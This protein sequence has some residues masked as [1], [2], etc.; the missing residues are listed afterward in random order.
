MSALGNLIIRLALNTAEFTGPLDKAE[1]QAKQ[2]M[3][4][5]A[6][7]VESVRKNFTRLAVAFAAG[8][9]IK[10]L[11]DVFDGV[12]KTAAGLDDLAESTG[13]TVESLSSMTGVAKLAG[14]SMESIGTALQKLSKGLVNADEETKGA[15]KALAALGISA[16]DSAGQL[17]SPAD[18]MKEVAASLAEYR[19]GAAKTA[20]VQDLFGK[21]G[22]Q[23]LPFLKDLADAGEL[24]A[25]ITSEQ[26]AQAEQYEKAMKRL[27]SEV[28]AWKKTV[29]LEVIPAAAA[30]V[31]V[32]ADMAAESNKANAAARK[33]AKDGYFRSWADDAALSIAYVIDMVMEFKDKLVWAVAKIKL[34]WDG[35]AVGMAAALTGP[36]SDETKR[37]IAIAMETERTIAEIEKETAGKRYDQMQRRLSLAQKVRDAE[38]GL[39]DDVRDKMARGEKQILQYHAAGE[40]GAE[41]HKEKL[42]DLDKALAEINKKMNTD[43]DEARLIGALNIAFQ[44]GKVSVGEYAEKLSFLIGSLASVKKA[45]DDQVTALNASRAAQHAAIDEIIRGADSIDKQAESLEEQN[46]T[47]GVAKSSLEAL[48]IARLQN[49]KAELD[50]VEGNDETVAALEREI[51]ARERLRAALGN[52]EA[53]QAEQEAQRQSIESFRQGWETVDRTARDVFISGKESIQNLKNFLKS[54][55]IEYLYRMTLQKW[56]FQIYANVSG[57]GAGGAA[58]SAMQLASGS[59]GGGSLLNMGSNLVGSWWN[60]EGIMGGLGAAMFGNAA[61]YSAAVPGLSFG[62]SQ[63]AMLAAQTG[64]FGLAGLTA[65]ASAGGGTML[66]SL[67]AAAPYIAAIVAVVAVLWNTFKDA[68]ENPRLQLGFGSQVQAYGVDGVFGREG[69]I[70]TAMPDAMNRGMQQFFEAFRPMDT[71]LYGQ[72]TDAQRAQVSAGLQQVNQREFAFPRGDA[73]AGEQVMLQ[74]MKDKYS[75][76]F[77]ALNQNI[78]NLIKGFEGK[79]DDLARILG[80]MAQIDFNKLPDTIKAEFDKLK[81]LDPKA[82]EGL[83]QLAATMST[84]INMSDQLGIEFNRLSGDNLKALIKEMGGAQQATQQLS[85]YY[86]NFVSDADKFKDAQASIQ[87][88]FKGIGVE[89]PTTRD[90]FRQLVSGLDLTTEKGRTLF[91]QLMQISPAFAQFAAALEKFGERQQAL[92]DKYTPRSLEQRL[93]AF[94]REFDALGAKAPQTAAELAAMA[95]GLDLSTDRGR[96]MLDLLERFAGTFDE[97]AA[98]AQQAA[99]R[100]A[101]S[102]SG[103]QN[104]MG[105]LSSDW[106]RQF[107]EMMFN[108]SVTNF[109]NMRGDQSLLG[110]TPQQWR[111]WVSG[112]GGKPVNLGNADQNNALTQILQWASQLLRDT[113]QAARGLNEFNGAVHDTAVVADDSAQRLA[114][115]INRQRSLWERYASEPEKLARAQADLLIGFAALGVSVPRSADEFAALVKGI[116]PTTDAGQRLLKALEALA[117]A[118]DAVQAATNRALDE[119]LAAMQRTAQLIADVQAF[120]GQVQGAAQQMRMQMSTFDAAGYWRGQIAQFRQ[121]MSA[122]TDTAGR[123]AAGQGLQNS[124]VQYANSQIATAS[125]L[126]D[127][128]L[129]DLQTE[130]TRQ[131]ELHR[132]QLDSVKQLADAFKGLG[133]YAKSLLTSELSPLTNEQKLAEAQGQFRALLTRAR[134]GDADAARQLQGAAQTYLQQ[135]RQF[136][137][138]SGAYTSIFEEVQGALSGLG[139]SARDVLTRFET[140][141]LQLQR[142][143]REYQRQRAAIE[144][145]FGRQTLQYQRDAVTALDELAAETQK[146]E[147]ELRQQLQRQAAAIVNSDATLSQILG[148]VGRLS[149]DIG[150]AVAQAV[151]DALATER[152]PVLGPAPRDPGSGDDDAPPTRL[153]AG[154]PKAALMVEPSPAFALIVQSMVSGELDKRSEQSR[155]AVAGGV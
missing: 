132:T 75:V 115:A 65:T 55:L 134:G 99:Q 67:A 145:E 4:K 144:D 27:A 29:A 63:A 114:E 113:P 125:R 37:V 20:V 86:Q 151:R 56:V 139:A 17:K 24:N 108:Q 14:T 130:Y 79:S 77:G 8:F 3:D 128:R 153:V 62:G 81:S 48:T 120:R 43:Y 133:E 2:A 91:A 34:A 45:H 111:D 54:E 135:G 9:S 50:G 119:A 49:R 41:K 147:T 51:Q 12:V 60:G 141:S 33:M 13:S 122:A 104:A 112:L 47:I 11:H 129:A 93:A 78:G 39:Y 68:G 5:I 87:A 38:A 59:N 64:E 71:Q 143:D 101:D 146:W 121:Q 32:L 22:A 148:A 25:K 6:D 26:A 15:G 82:M 70:Q 44:L 97:A 72:M 46:R 84:L 98:A 94:G 123:L 107:A 18:M 31:S 58:G 74:Y 103:L 30:F 66:S 92:V 73:T 105:A 19:D 100:M 85:A 102:I 76:V 83:L 42:T 89:M 109:A 126:R 127:Q 137:A 152:K 96:R 21:S 106:S 154:K 110:S 52:A 23:L 57:G 142:D 155:N 80:V 35:A 140:E 131:Q 1:H 61:A 36:F 7:S 138:S 28:D 149:G 90:G 88:A 117:P 95:Q 150:A 10:A 53:I 124:I 136:Y 116:D 16:K 69:F 40:K 118:F